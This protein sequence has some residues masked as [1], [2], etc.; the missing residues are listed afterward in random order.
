MTQS[1]LAR[2]VGCAQSAVSMFESGHPEKLSLDFV[3]KIAELLD[4]PL[5]EQVTPVAPESQNRA[6]NQNCYCPNQLCFS[7]IPYVLNGDLFLWPTLLSCTEDDI[8]CKI[9]GEVLERACPGCGA[10][11]DTG[12]FCSLCGEPRIT[13][14][15]PAQNSAEQY[16]ENQR[17]AIAQWRALTAGR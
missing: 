4:I 5:E 3:R 8:Y 10:P 15:L 16:A 13:A 1:A 14:T 9:C 6:G 12:A 11:L 17:A 7:N 2:S